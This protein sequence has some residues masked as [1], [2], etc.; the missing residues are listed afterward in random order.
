MSQDMT[1]QKDPLYSGEPDARSLGLPWDR[2]GFFASS[3]CAVH[4]M[5]LPWLL[6]VMPFLASTWLADRELERGF[7]IASIFLAVACTIGGC[8]VHGR[9]WLL[10]L[11]GAGALALLGAHATAPPAC[12]SQHLSWPHALGAACGGG[13]LAATHFFNLRLQRTSAPASVSHCCNES[14]CSGSPTWHR[15]DYESPHWR[16]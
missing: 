14:D 1:P 11:L 12:C 9:W 7:V 13:L 10:G 4:C 2:L 8:R 6:L 5:C 3:V 15:R 16:V